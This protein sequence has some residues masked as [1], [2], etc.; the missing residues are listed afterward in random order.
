MFSLLFRSFSVFPVIILSTL[1][2]A[3]SSSLWVVAVLGLVSEAYIFIV[4]PYS[5]IKASC[6]SICF[7][8]FISHFFVQVSIARSQVFI[9]IVYSILMP[10]ISILDL[11]GSLLITVVLVF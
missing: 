5:G 9:S 8:Y 10:S 11:V 1:S 3:V 6:Q 2:S 7:L 4:S